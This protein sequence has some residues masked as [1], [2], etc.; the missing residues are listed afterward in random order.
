[1]AVLLVSVR[2]VAAPADSAATIA[3]V[4]GS[5]CLCPF[6]SLFAEHHGRAS[7]LLYYTAKQCVWEDPVGEYQGWLQSCIT[8]FDS[9]TLPPF[10]RTLTNATT[11]R[12]FYLKYDDLSSYLSR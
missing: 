8:R 6:V 4:I 3:V 7:Y 1:M 12:R 9:R 11:F 10:Q 2:P 5:I